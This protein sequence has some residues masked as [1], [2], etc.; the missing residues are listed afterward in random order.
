VTN[1]VKSAQSKGYLGLILTSEPARILVKNAIR[2]ELPDVGVLSVPEI[3]AGFQVEGL[4]EINI[5][6]FEEYREN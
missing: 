5:R 3:E 4:G 1:S 2:R 6:E